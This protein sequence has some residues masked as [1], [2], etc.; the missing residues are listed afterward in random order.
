MDNYDEAI[1]IERHPVFFVNRAACYEKLG[2]YESG[3]EDGRSAVAIDKNFAKGYLRILQC[4][5]ALGDSDAAEHALTRIRE[6][7]ANII[8]DADI[9]KLQQLRMHDIDCKSFQ[10]PEQAISHADDALKV[11]P[12]YLK[13]KLLKADAL[14]RLGDYQVSKNLSTYSFCTVFTFCHTYSKAKV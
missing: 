8:S 5:V 10:T 6:L 12:A 11:A 2:K 3:R 14:A 13:F 9:E 1:S 7:E 4:S